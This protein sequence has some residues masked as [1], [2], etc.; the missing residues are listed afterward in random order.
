MNEEDRKFEVQI[1]KTGLLNWY[2]IGEVYLVRDYRFNCAYSVVMEGK[3]T[4]YR[5][6]KLDYKLR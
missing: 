6:P 3:F 4:G 5:I 2:A 1:T